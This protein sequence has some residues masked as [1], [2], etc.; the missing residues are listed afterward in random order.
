MPICVRNA[1]HVSAD[2]AGERLCLCGCECRHLYAALP[3]AQ[4]T[5]LLGRELYL[6]RA[7]GIQQVLVIRGADDRHDQEVLVHQ[8]GQ[9]DLVRRA[10]D[11]LPRSAGLAEGALRSVGSGNPGRARRRW[12][13]SRSR[14]RSRGSRRAGGPRTRLD[15]D[16]PQSAWWARVPAASSACRDSTAAAKPQ[17]PTGRER[18]HRRW[19]PRSGPPASCSLPGTGCGLAR[20]PG[21]GSR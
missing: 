3:L 12:R 17:S 18:S 16:P 9:R 7:E 19:L 10:T 2:A 14:W 11:A 4:P 1:I 8:V 21:S 20:S 13:N 6:H 5:H 15:P